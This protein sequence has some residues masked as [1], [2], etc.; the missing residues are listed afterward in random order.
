M[1]Y[2]LFK[3]VLYTVLLLIN[4]MAA[5]GVASLLIEH[6]ADHPVGK[7][8]WQVAVYLFF[9]FYFKLFNSRMVSSNESYLI[10]KANILALITIFSIIFLLKESESYSR[11]YVLVFFIFNGLLPVSVY[12]I[13]RQMMRLSWLREEIIVVCDKS[14][15]EN[16]KLWFLKDN[17]FGFDVANYIFIDDKQNRPRSELNKILNSQLY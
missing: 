1:R 2:T 14:G 12:V 5:Y 10:I 4:L 7:Y 16:I 11:L 15:Y 6:I 17:A 9:Y 3:I 8:I 13:K